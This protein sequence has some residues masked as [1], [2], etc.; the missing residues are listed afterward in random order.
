MVRSRRHRPRG[1]AAITT[2]P[3]LWEEALP[4]PA[5]LTVA[6]LSGSHHFWLLSVCRLLDCARAGASSRRSRARARQ[7]QQPAS[8]RAHAHA[9]ITRDAEEGDVGPDEGAQVDRVDV[10]E[11]VDAHDGVCDARPRSKRIEETSSSPEV[12]LGAMRSASRQLRHGSR[13]K[14]PRLRWMDAHRKKSA[15]LGNAPFNPL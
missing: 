11:E 2:P 14:G 7:R 5:G 13:P 9:P 12:R 3:R 8:A 10:A 1:A 15:P 4:R 6:G